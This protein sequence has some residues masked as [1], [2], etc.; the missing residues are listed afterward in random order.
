MTGKRNFIK[1]GLRVGCGKSY[2]G[3]ARQFKNQGK[4]SFDFYNIKVKL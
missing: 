4:V 1:V 3:E 2:F